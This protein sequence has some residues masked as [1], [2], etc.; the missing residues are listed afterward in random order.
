MHKTAIILAAA[1]SNRL[2]IEKEHLT[3][4]EHYITGLE[5]AMGKVFQKVG[6]SLTSKQ[7]NLML[8]YLRAY[9]ELA[10]DRLWYNCMTQMSGK[11]F[12]RALADGLAAGVFNLRQTKEGRLISRREGLQL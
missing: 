10:E 1:E 12:K 4:A 2:V 3:Q 8:D 11:E 5:V 9:G 7:V 6:E